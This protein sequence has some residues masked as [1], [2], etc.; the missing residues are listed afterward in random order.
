[1]RALKYFESEVL[2]VDSLNREESTRGLKCYLSYFTEV[3]ATRNFASRPHR[4]AGVYE[5]DFGISP[6]TSSIH[7]AH[8]KNH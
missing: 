5:L 1:M 7:S 8:N 4:K 3:S 6:T 2:S